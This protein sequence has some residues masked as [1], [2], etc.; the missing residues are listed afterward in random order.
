LTSTI[1]DWP[2]LS[3]DNQKS[4]GEGEGG[5]VDQIDDS[6]D[7][8]A[9]C[10]QR[11]VQPR[12]IVVKSNLRLGDVWFYRKCVLLFVMAQFVIDGTAEI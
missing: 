1:S 6:H 5:E 7:R 12:W 11:S 3:L 8:S 2:G 10:N 9:G 4:E